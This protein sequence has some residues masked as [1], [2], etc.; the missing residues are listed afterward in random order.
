MLQQTSWKMT[1]PV[2]I[3][4]AIPASEHLALYR[5]AGWWKDGEDESRLS[6]IISGSF[7]TAAAYDSEGRCI[8]MGRMISDGASDGYIQDVVVFNAYRGHGIGA[9]LVKLLK[10]EGL[11]R[12][13][14]WI[15]L[16]AEPGTKA[17]YEKLG[18]A[19]MDNYV[20][21]LLKR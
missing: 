10:D 14:S 3:V 1:Y 9:A 7:L 19:E 2:R 17:F 16:I 20:P 18:F 5:D 13:L 15:G 6:L 11:A 4:D 21:M 12:G 8:G